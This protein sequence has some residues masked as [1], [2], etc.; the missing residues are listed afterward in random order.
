MAL[1]TGKKITWKQIGALIGILAAFIGIVT[2]AM[3]IVQ[4]L[5]NRIDRFEGDVTQQGT[6]DSFINFAKDH[7]TKVVWLNITCVR[8]SLS[9]SCCA[10]TRI[11][12]DAPPQMGKDI[13][14]SVHGTSAKY[15]FHINAADSDAQINNG[16]YGA[17]S[18]V[19][20]GYF[21][22]SVQG[23]LGAEPQ[24]VQNVFLKGIDSSTTKR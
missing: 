24:D 9:V 12:C 23:V 15:W 2:G 3:A 20:K 14:L 19:I 17:G 13:I 11:D 6:A 8:G 4:S 16:S 22:F 1:S 5:Q 10:A 18:L 21:E 7:D